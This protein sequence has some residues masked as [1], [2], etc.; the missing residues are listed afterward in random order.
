MEQDPSSLGMDTSQH[1]PAYAPADEL[2]VNDDNNDNIDNDDN[3]GT[4]GNVDNDTPELF[5]EPKRKVLQRSVQ[6]SPGWLRS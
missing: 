1:A 5:A 2:L 6:L 4:A 3:D